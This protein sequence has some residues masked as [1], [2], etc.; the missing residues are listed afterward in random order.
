MT[1]SRRFAF[2][3]RLAVGPLA[4]AG[5][6]LPWA[7]GPGVLA[8]NQ[9]TG[10]RLVGVAG[11]FQ[12]LDLG[13]AAENAIVLLRFAVLGVAIAAIWQS[14]LAPRW[15]WHL[16]YLLSGWYLVAF[17]IVAT[18]VGLGRVG[19]SIPPLGLIL[20]IVAAAFF[21]TCELLRLRRRSPLPQGEG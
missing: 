18:A 8:A 2:I 21:G 4:L 15:R 11:R 1:Y 5:F 16:G 6:F 19:L 14:I 7:H 13:L 9:F 17:A 10:Y 12:E 3:L 20:V